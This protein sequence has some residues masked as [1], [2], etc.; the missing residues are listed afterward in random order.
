MAV[1]DARALRAALRLVLAP[2]EA[3]EVAARW[4][5]D[6]NL[7]DLG[8]VARDAIGR[9]RMERL[10][11]RLPW[12]GAERDKRLL[13]AASGVPAEAAVA[14]A[15]GP[16][17]RLDGRDLAD[18]LDVRVE[19]VGEWLVAGRRAL[20][21]G[22]A[23]PCRKTAALVGRYEDRSLDPDERIELIT[24]LNRCPTC[25]EVVERSRVVDAAIT[26]EFGRLRVAFA[27]RAVVGVSRLERTRRSAI[28]A[29][30]ALLAVVVLIAGGAGISRLVDGPDEPV[31]LVA[32]VARTPYS[33]WLVIGRGDGSVQARHVATGETQ[34]IFE[35]EDP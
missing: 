19:R 5:D 31:P 34:R 17:L 29:G 12:R 11:A 13:D 15:L 32:G 10:L 26:D 2:G 18:V 3:D 14:L 27:D 25:Q 33:G 20:D 30:V 8:P 1:V 23:D 16:G 9:A 6:G 22:M 28:V 35:S 4:P 7:D 24:H 21:R